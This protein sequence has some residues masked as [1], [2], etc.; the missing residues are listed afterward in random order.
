MVYMIFCESYLT[1]IYTRIYMY[2][3]SAEVQRALKIQPLYCVSIS[4][5]KTVLCLHY[6]H[7]YELHCICY[8]FPFSISMK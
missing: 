3:C 7:T 8:K 6:T 5:I 1:A 4:T 2:I